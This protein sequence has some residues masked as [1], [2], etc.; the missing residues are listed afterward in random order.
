M[1]EKCGIELLA[2]L[3]ER[4][5]P[6]G[7]E[8][9]VA[10]AI[11]SQIG[12]RCD[13]M[14][15]DTL[16]NVYAVIYG[17]GENRK[18]IMISAHMDEVGFMVTGVGDNGYIKFSTL[19][20]I[21]PRVFYGKQ[22]TVGNEDKRIP[23][24]IAAKAIHHKKKEDR[25]KVTKISDMYMD[26]G[27]SDGEEAGKYVEVGDFAAFR[28]DFVR[29]GENDNF[30]KGKAIDDRAGCS[31]MIEVI[32]K[33]RD[34]KIL[35]PFDLYFCFTV[36]EEVG[37]SGAK[38]AAERIK[39]DRAIILE[40]TAIADIADVPAEKRV[41]DVGEGGVL[42]IMDRST[43]YDSAFVRFA[44]DCAGK[45]GI[46]VQVKRY[47]SGGNDAG[48]IHKSGVG[49]HCIALSLPTRYLHSAA[50]VASTEDYNSVKELVFAMLKEMRSEDNDV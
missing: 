44:L 24:V 25:Y 19:G 6:T 31:A 4:F 1:T 47:V 45:Y 32:R 18:R 9:E 22:V 38:V 41:A 50:C 15:R 8:T 20:G 2:Y 7:C 33:I 42:S 13:K 35:F 11:I 28:S 23:G 16:G 14:V 34:E 5:G 29:F 12:D 40:S 37:L 10:D 26:I 48:H 21:D 46:K 39:P 49:V 30:I 43:I 17:T 27:A 36:R 3:C